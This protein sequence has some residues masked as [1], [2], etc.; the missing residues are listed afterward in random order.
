MVVVARVV[1]VLGAIQREVLVG[2]HAAVVRGHVL[3]LVLARRGLVAH[4][5]ALHHRER[6]GIHDGLRLGACRTSAAVTRT[7]TR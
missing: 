2:H 5:D 1:V 4:G 3:V 7:P 6:G